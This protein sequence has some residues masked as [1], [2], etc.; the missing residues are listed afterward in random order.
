MVNVVPQDKNLLGPGLSLA[1]C[2]SITQQAKPDDVW[3]KKFIIS[4]PENP[5]SARI[6]LHSA[7][8]VRP[9]N[10]EVVL[11]NLSSAVQPAI[12][13][14]QQSHMIGSK[15]RIEIQT[16]K[17]EHTVAPQG[18]NRLLRRREFKK[19]EVELKAILGKIGVKN[20]SLT[21]CSLSLN[22]VWS[23]LIG[24]KGEFNFSHIPYLRQIHDQYKPKIGTQAYDK[25]IKE[26]GFFA[27][28]KFTVKKESPDA[29]I[30][31]IR[32]NL[33]TGTRS[34]LAIH[35]QMNRLLKAN[36][37]Q[38]Y[39]WRSHRMISLDDKKNQAA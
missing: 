4:P 31:K 35:R 24:V 39:D 38:I 18:G 17:S 10:E 25:I 27:D 15:L 21:L 7:D 33:L 22:G 37:G 20:L 29:Y 3:L 1:E 36:K 2:L 16:P 32:G 11:R 26:K 23:N 13:M 6:I 14:H 8:E 28:I 34:Q 12:Q 19:L 5:L 9:G 30:G